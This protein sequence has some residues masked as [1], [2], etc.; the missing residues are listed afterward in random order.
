[1]IQNDCTPANIVRELQ[2]ILQ[3]GAR[4]S[5][6]I[7]ELQSVRDKLRDHDRAE[8]PALRAAKEILAELGSTIKQA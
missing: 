1:L 7:A 4:R 5:Q 8:P 3:E 6:I 2:T